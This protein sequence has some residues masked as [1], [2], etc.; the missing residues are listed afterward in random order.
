MIYGLDV[1]HHQKYPSKVPWKGQAFGCIRITW[2]DSGI[3]AL[4]EEHMRHARAAGVDTIV[5]YH[6]QKDQSGSA[7]ANHFHKRRLELETEFGPLACAN[8]LEDMLDSSGKPIPWNLAKYQAATAS[9][10]GRHREICQR[11]ILIYGNSHDLKRY[12]VAAHIER[13]PL[14]LADWQAPYPAPMPWEQWTILQYKGGGLTGFDQN[15]FDGTLEEL[16]ALLL[17]DVVAPLSFD[18]LGPVLTSVR[19]AEGRGATAETF[20]NRDEGPKID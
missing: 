15:R 14:W 13:E 19:A 9:F 1:S 10:V 16:R 20:V 18:T 17:P 11:P 5:A 3:D 12:A 4:A 7:Q 8:D 6:Y 2:G